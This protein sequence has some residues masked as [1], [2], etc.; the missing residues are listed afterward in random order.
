MSHAIRMFFYNKVTMNQ[1]INTK[2][3]RR[4]GAGIAAVAAV[5]LMLSTIASTGAFFNDSHD[6]NIAGTVGTIKIV[7]SGGSGT[8][9]L[10]LAFDNLLP[11]EPQTVSFDYEN[12]GNNPQDVWLVFPNAEA[13][14]ALNDLGSY[15]EA[16]VSANGVAVFDSANLKDNQAGTC[17]ALSPTGCWPLP[18]SL[19][20]ASNV[21]PGATGSVDFTFGYASK[22]QSQAP[23]NAPSL[24]N[25]YPLE[26]PTKS[27]LPY[28]LVATQAGK[29]LP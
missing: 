12:T 25:V 22:L 3:N 13:L 16:H 9:G 26:A 14:H 23:G 24:W 20:L 6:G 18:K 27:G 11:G 15:G 21:A 29:A 28:Q 5:G 10:D 8:E 1:K 7:G 17:G 19:K 2:R 4:V